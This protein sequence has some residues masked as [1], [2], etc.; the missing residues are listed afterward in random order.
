LVKSGDQFSLTSNTS[1]KPT[2]SVAY[3]AGQLDDLA[4]SPK[5][6]LTNDDFEFL[7][8]MTGPVVPLQTNEADNNKPSKKKKV[9]KSSTKQDDTDSTTTNT[10]YDVKK[11]K[12]SSKKQQADANDAYPESKPKSNKSKTKVKASKKLPNF[13]ND[14][15]DEDNDDNRSIHIKPDCDYEEI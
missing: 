12:K 15:N 3:L 1:N 9:R 14:E 10:D 4:L 8:K 11:K 13:D 2:R 7:E 6:K 5:I